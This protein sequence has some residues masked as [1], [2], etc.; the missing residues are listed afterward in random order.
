MLN[1]SETIR[2]PVAKDG[3]F[4]LP[5]KPPDG[6]GE[7]KEW[8]AVLWPVVL[9]DPKREW[10]ERGENM[11]TYALSQAAVGEA[12][13]LAAELIT[14]GPRGGKR[15]TRLKNRLYGVVRAINSDFI[16]LDVYPDARAAILESNRARARKQGGGEPVLVLEHQAR[17][18]RALIEKSVG[19]LRE[20]EAQLG[21]QRMLDFEE[22]CLRG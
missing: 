16:E 9:E 15:N 10:I 6:S 8:A 3:S 20:I 22:E 17:S 13:E 18:L 21:V 5:I 19:E 2:V 4:C 14:N 1:P 12:V 7:V 11:N